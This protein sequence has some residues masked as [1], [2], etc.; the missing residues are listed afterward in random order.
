MTASGGVA[1]SNDKTCACVLGGAGKA[2]NGEGRC[3]CIMAGHGKDT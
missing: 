3:V 2:K 1:D